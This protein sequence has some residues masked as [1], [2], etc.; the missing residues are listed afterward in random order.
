M[1][2]IALT[3]RCAARSRAPNFLKPGKFAVLNLGERALHYSW[4][5]GCDC[6]FVEIFV[7]KAVILFLLASAVAARADV[8]DN[9]STGAFMQSITTGTFVL[10]QAGA[11]STGERDVQ[12]N[13]L[14][15]PFNQF[16]DVSVGSGMN[17]VSNGFGVVSKVTLQYDVNGDEVGNTGAGKVLTNSGSGSSI[18]LGANPIVRLNFAGNDLAVT[19]RVV[20][21]NSGAVIGEA[22][23]IKNP[24]G[25]GVLDLVL[26][27]AAM[28]SA[29]SISIEFSADPSGDFAL[30][31]VEA[32]PE[33]AT[34]AALGIGVAAMMRR[35]RK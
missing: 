11:M 31:S 20:L 26:G 35:R 29:D 5:V 7:K 34:M 13:V 25:A 19:A 24:G 8:I 32:V 30:T 22:V 17:V 18:G 28:S 10:T 14:G 6:Q 4:A 21:R 3:A 27:S 23:G 16:L 15:N 12:M 33:P 2:I 1:R 9:F